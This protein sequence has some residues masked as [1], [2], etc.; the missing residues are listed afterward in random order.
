MC[1]SSVNVDEL[2]ELSELSH[3]EYISKY[4][5]HVIIKISSLIWKNPRIIKLHS[6]RAIYIHL[7][8][9]QLGE[10]TFIPAVKLIKQRELL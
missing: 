9:S 6:E 3:P 1:I 8:D 10:S 4:I 7:N 2:H 5:I